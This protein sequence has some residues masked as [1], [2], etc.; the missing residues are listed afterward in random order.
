MFWACR[1][2]A[3][4]CWMTEWCFGNSPESCALHDVTRMRLVEDMRSAFKHFASQARLAAI[5]YYDWT[6]TPSNKDSW[7]VFRCGALTDDG[8][9]ALSPM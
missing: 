5:I 1:Q 9:L 8:K 4:P 3:K 6:G 7:A 2:G